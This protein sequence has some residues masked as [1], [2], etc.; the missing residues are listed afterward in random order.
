MG[1]FLFDR[2]CYRH[3][4][5]K[6]ENKLIEL[7]AICNC[8]KCS[9]RQKLYKNSLRNQLTV[10]VK[11]KNKIGKAKEFIRTWECNK[12]QRSIKAEYVDF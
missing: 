5:V 10:T 9:Y 11:D 2:V 12:Q 7:H 4:I 1:E 6:P 8:K 3:G